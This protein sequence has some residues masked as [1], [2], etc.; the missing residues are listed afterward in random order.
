MVEIEKE[1][2]KGLMDKFQQELNQQLGES[3]QAAYRQEVAQGGDTVPIMSREY[4]QFKSEYLPKGLTF[5]EKA[6]NFF[7]GL[8]KLPPAQ[9]KKEQLEE[10]IKVCH[11]N[12]TPTGVNTF[13]LLAPFTF[14]LF[15]AAISFIL[16]NGGMFFP[17][18]FVILAAAMIKPFGQIPINAAAKIRMDAGSQMVL[19]VFYVVTYMRHTSNLELAIDFAAEHLAPPLSMDFKKIMWD[20]ETQKCESIKESLDNYLSTWKGYNDDFIEAFHLIESSLFEGAEDKRISMLDKSLGVILD[21][22]F[23]KMLHYAQGLSGPMTTLNMLG[24][25]LPVLGLVI[26]P[27]VVSFMEGIG[28]YHISAL[29]NVAIPLSVFFLGRKVLLTRPSGHGQID[30]SKNPML[31]KYKNMVFNIGGKEIL[32]S[33]LW[34]SIIVGMILLFIGMLPV[35]LH[36]VAPNFDVPIMGDKFKLL[37]YHCPQKMKNCTIAEQIGPYGLGATMLSLFVV[38]AAGIPVGLYYKK[39]SANVMEIRKQSK[40][41]EEEFASAL[42]QLGNRMG[43]GLP[44]EMAFGRVAESMSGTVSGGFFELVN[45]N[46]IR[47]GM[48]VEQSIFDPVHG[49]LV[50]YPS[51]LIESSM[52]VLTESS[53]K[54]PEVT[55]QALINIS[56]YLKQMHKVEEKLNDLLSETIGSM[57]AQIKFLTPVITA[58]VIGITSMVSTILGKLSG[59][60]KKIGEEGDASQAGGLMGLFGDGVPTFYFQA[61]VGLYVVQI[62]YILTIMANGVENG[63]DKLNERYTLGQN[64]FGAVLTYCALAFVIIL[65]FNLIAGAVIAK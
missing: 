5:Y 26:L 34:Y 57:K 15:G 13:A 16:T 43:D 21:G 32:I 8:V 40:K 24:V 20:V 36:M 4:E 28:W 19:S 45:E 46:I 52:K 25:I 3:K 23:E 22:T 12:I 41:L 11:L 44:A 49:A 48:S 29:Y 51:S 58:I 64:M 63:N 6:C 7:E 65:A 50:Q 27:L 17:A 14:G 31:K 59:Q 38:V 9:K 35:T 42:F 37:D 1:E 39:R 2:I 62:I 10:A 61:V 54:G 60:M 33:P 47:M 55:A 30:I 18:F 56:A 53:K